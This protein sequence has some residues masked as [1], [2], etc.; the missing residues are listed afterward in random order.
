MRIDAKFIVVVIAVGTALVLCVGMTRSETLSEH[1]LV[2]QWFCF[3]VSVCVSAMFSVNFSV[4]NRSQLNQI[5]NWLGLCS[6]YGV[7]IFKD[8]E[9]SCCHYLFTTVFVVICF[10]WIATLKWTR[11]S[12]A[13]FCVLLVPAVTWLALWLNGRSIWQAEYAT[14][15]VFAAFWCLYT[16]V[17]IYDMDGPPKHQWGCCV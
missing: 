5:L 12:V 16:I 14:F 1:M 9:T 11:V 4:A 2:S 3:A 10:L 13:W 17:N 8:F 7:I 15:F 6:W